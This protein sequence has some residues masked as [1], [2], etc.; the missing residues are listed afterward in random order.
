MPRDVEQGDEPGHNAAKR[1]GVGI[2]VAFS[3]GV[4]L[5]ALFFWRVRS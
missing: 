4:L 5:V 2:S 3:I 1:M